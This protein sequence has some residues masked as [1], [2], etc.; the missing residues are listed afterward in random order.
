MLGLLVSTFLRHRRGIFILC[1]LAFSYGVFRPE[2]PP[3]LFEDSDKAWHILAFA[4]LGFSAALALD[5][6]PAWL[7]WSAMIAAAPLIEWLQHI[8]QPV[9]EFS[10]GDIWGNLVGVLLGYLA[11]MMFRRLSHLYA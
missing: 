1:L 7:L 4:G 10:A 3:Q 2:P 6:L 8:A 9:R 5:R 11:W